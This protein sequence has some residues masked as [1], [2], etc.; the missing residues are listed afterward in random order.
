MDTKNIVG[1]LLLHQ[2]LSGYNRQQANPA[3]QGGAG[4]NREGKNPSPGANSQGPESGA[5]GPACSCELPEEVRAPIA[6]V[7]CSLW[8]AG[9]EKL[10]ISSVFP[11]INNLF[12]CF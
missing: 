2:M 12:L 10:T 1:M 3:W 8:P 5:H 4:A 7:L 9:Q 11:V 6:H